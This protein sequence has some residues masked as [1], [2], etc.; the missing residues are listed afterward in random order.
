MLWTGCQENSVGSDVDKEEE[1]L[2]EE[3]IED[4]D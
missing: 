1:E 3:L 4:N 2:I